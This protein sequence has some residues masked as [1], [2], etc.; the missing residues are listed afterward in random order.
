MVKLTCNIDT[1]YDMFIIEG[2]NMITEFVE[3]I[4][5]FNNFENVENQYSNNFK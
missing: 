3:K 5:Q 2:Y 1:K 4:A